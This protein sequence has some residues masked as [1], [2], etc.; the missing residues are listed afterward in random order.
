MNS[1]NLLTGILVTIFAGMVFAVMDSVGKTLTALIPIVQ[2][3]WG[4]YMVQ[5]VLMTVYLSRTTGTRFLKTRRPVLQLLRGAML[6]AATFS[7]YVSL[8]HIPLADA[9]SV[10]FFSPII[11]TILS[12]VFLKERVG[13]H[14]IA[15]ILAGFCGVMLI[16]RPGLS[17]TSPYLALPLLAAFFNSVF[18]L[19]TRQ[20]ADED[21]AAATQFNTTAVGAA[22]LSVAVIP[23][24]ETPAPATVGLMLLIGTVGSIGHFSLVTAFRH[25]P[26]SLLS[27]FLY[28]QVLFA[29]AISILWFGDPMGAT[30]LIGTA[31]LIASGLYIWWR[32][33]RTARKRLLAAEAAA[34][35]H[36]PM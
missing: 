15:A 14:R 18:L 28:S 19:L 30:T 32:E 20:L 5:T 24:W 6:I 31:V 22:I 34:A 3:V 11:I 21:E 25:A 36:G 23:V 8:S 16:V 2:V 4:R 9:T 35:A 33:N 1:P 17:D 29:S 12:V 27:P 26:A 10:L 13:I 7:M